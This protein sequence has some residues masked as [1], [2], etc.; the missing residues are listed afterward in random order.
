MKNNKPLVSVIIP[1]YNGALY[2][3]ETIHSV[4]QSTYKN[5]E[6]I[7]VN[8]GSTDNSEQVC[9]KLAARHR[10]IH[11]FSL[12]K[13]KGLSNT[14]N[15]AI[16][17]ARGIYIA[18]LNQDDR[19]MP[20]RLHKQIEFLEREKGHV[21]VGGMI[22]LFDDNGNIFD[23]VSFPTTD[24]KL[25]KQWMTLSP[26]SDPTVMYRKETF[27]KTDGY[28]Q[29]YWPVDDVHMWYQLGKFGK[30]A[31]LPLVLTQVRWN[32][33]VGSVKSHKLQMKK[34][35]KLHVWA[36]KH[37]Q[38]AGLYEWAFWTSQLAAGTLLPARFNWKVYRILRKIRH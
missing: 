12:P 23:T 11:F 27:L 32:N 2:I 35:F 34:L 1:V 31:N 25:K 20:Y 28:K 18:R 22:E 9:K 37:I 15:V 36:S 26:F 13:N 3:E 8:D 38:K 6:I 19:M 7:L 33:H 10:V 14:L 24:S 21:A 5:F 17:K 4:L 30:L 16:A 29:E